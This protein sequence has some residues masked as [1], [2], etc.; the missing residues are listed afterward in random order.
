[1]AVVRSPVP[2]GRIAGLDTA[3]AR[4]RPGVVLVLTA[5]DLARNGPLPSFDTLPLSISATL[6]V[7]AE[8]HVLYAGQPI[9]AVVAD[10]IDH[11][12]AAGRAIAVSIEQLPALR[13]VDDALEPG[14]TA[15]HGTGGLER[16]DDHDR[17]GGN[18]VHVLNHRVGA[19]EQAFAEAAH[20]VEE[21]FEFHRVS[22]CPMEPRGAEAWRETGTGRLVVRATTQVPGVARDAIADLLGLPRAA[23][24]Y[25]PL[26]LGG[27]FGLKEA[28]YA[29]EVLVAVAALHLGRRVRW[30]E[31]RAEHFAGSSHARQGNVTVRIALDRDGTVTALEVDGLSDIGAGYSLAGNSPGAATGAMMRGPYRIPNLL[32]HTR[33]IVTN[34]T[35]LNVYRGAGHPQAVFAMER[36]MDRAAQALQ[37]DRVAI[38]RRNLILPDAFPVDRE[39]AYPGAGRIVYDSGDYERGLDE[40]LDAIDASGFDTRRKAFQADHPGQK[41]G[42][43]LSLMVEL[44]A[45]GPDESVSLAVGA[46]GRITAETS[47]VAIGQGAES[48]LAQ[49]LSAELGLHGSDIAVRCGGSSD[50][51]SGGG[52]FASRGVAVCGA[53]LADGAA[54]LKQTVIALTAEVMGV[55]PESLGWAEGGV[56]GLPARNAPLTLPELLARLPAGSERRLATVGTFAV[57]AST[58]ASGAHAAIVSVDTATGAV[59]VLDYAVAHDCGTVL[60][61]RGVDGQIVGG[62]MQG[63]G[64]TLLEDLP[65]DGAGVPLTRSFMDYTIPVAADVPRFHLRHVETPSRLNPLG[66]KGAG[67]GG[68]TGTP[69]ALV[70]AIEDALSSYGIVLRDDGP[71][72]PA[73]VLGLI[74][75]AS[76]PIVQPPLGEPD[77]CLR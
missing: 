33:S 45:T 47:N 35:P 74:R 57:A 29:E 42:F 48:A 22:A 69:A 70:G 56:V 20:V 18:A 54:K 23:I 34:K 6:P 26:R 11:A 63:L 58:F 21:R 5:A 3:A 8:T 76:P 2:H 67:E 75:D 44:T 39:V 64:A 77:R 9:A 51:P 31:T 53:A 73:R 17:P 32:A 61:P 28:V 27:G 14:C 60:D 13:S 43:G 15:L 72:T 62:V 46:D 1:M 55:S 4:V 59:A 7:L 38:R 40:V 65:F 19:P 41:L 24:A 52:T 71:Y 66:F 50:R 30:E 49:I 37:L 68:F 16:T 25:E 10:T 36:L 12:T